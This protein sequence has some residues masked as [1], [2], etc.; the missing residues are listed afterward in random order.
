MRGWPS[1]CLLLLQEFGALAALGCKFLGGDRAAIGR[2]AL[3][4]LVG[5]LRVPIG[6]LAL[7]DR[8]LVAG[9]A[10]PVQA[11]EQGIHGR[12]G[13][14]LAIGV[15]DPQQELAAHVPSV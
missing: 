14:A 13:R 1:G 15:L 8:R 5:D 9:E 2:A 10:E 3:H 4:Q 11:V 12:L 7:V 6:A